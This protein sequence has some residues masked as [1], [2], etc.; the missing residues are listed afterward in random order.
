MEELVRNAYSRDELA[1]SCHVCGDDLDI[2]QHDYWATVQH[3]EGEMCGPCADRLAT[4]IRDGT[5]TSLIPDEQ[6]LLIPTEQMALLPDAAHKPAPDAE[7]QRNQTTAKRMRY[8]YA[9]ALGWDALIR[10]TECS[11][12]PSD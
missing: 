2:S 1:V 11:N 7:P 10:K 3:Q 6:A 8:R 12:T 9:N 5:I 4:A